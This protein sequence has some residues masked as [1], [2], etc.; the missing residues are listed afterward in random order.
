MKREVKIEFAEAIGKLPLRKLTKDE[1]RKIQE[2][3]AEKY[4]QR[5]KNSKIDDILIGFRFSLLNYSKLENPTKIILLGQFINSII[6]EINSID[7]VKIRKE[8][9]A[10]YLDI[11]PSNIHKYLNGTRKFNIDHT[12]RFERI[13]KIQ[14]QIFLQ[15][16][17][18]NELI[19][20][21]RKS[22]GEYDKYSFNDLVKA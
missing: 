20:Q 21:K 6:K 14:A 16:Q 5:S 8:D 17:S 4:H 15:I 1:K 2:E 12:L 19:E 7:D 9:F 13:F 22:V 18:K 11:S 10:R 3:R